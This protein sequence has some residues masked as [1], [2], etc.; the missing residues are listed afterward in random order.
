M[1]PVGLEPTTYGLKEDS[2]PGQR[3]RSEHHNAFHVRK[4]H[5]TTLVGSDWLWKHCGL[6]ADQTLG[7]DPPGTSSTRRG[8]AGVVF[9]RGSS[10][11]GQPHRIFVQSA[12]WKTQLK[13]AT[14]VSVHR[15][16]PFLRRWNRADHTKGA[17]SPPGIPFTVRVKVATSADTEIQPLQGTTGM[18]ES[19][20]VPP[21]DQRPLPMVQVVMPA[22]S[23]RNS[24]VA[25]PPLALEMSAS[26]IE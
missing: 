21:T 25:L 17:Q 20:G 24:A 7:L 4:R 9:A 12:A 15:T 11:G 1:G 16:S 22:F 8:P 6:R 10:V 23:W 14:S 19:V 18:V 2:G 3:P 5:W 26:V 13:S